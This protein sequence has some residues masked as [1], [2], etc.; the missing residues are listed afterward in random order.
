M[1]MSQ[2]QDLNARRC[3]VKHSC[4]IFPSFHSGLYFSFDLWKTNLQSKL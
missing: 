1:D 4:L 2:L 3:Y